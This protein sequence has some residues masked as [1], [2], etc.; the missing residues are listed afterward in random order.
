MRYVAALCAVLL[1]SGSLSAAPRETRERG[2][3]NPVLKVIK[4]LV[5]GLGDGIVVPLPPPKP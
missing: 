1:V 4:R 3:E 2:R 5:S